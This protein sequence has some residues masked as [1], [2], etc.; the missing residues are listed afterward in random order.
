MMIFKRAALAV[1][2]G[3]AGGGTVIA[4]AAAEGPPL[5]AGACMGCHGADLA[6]VTPIVGIAGIHSEAE[7]IAIMTAFARNE[8][9]ATIMNR[10]AR[11]YS[12]AEIATLAAALAKR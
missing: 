5:I 8:R 6:G 7:F 12:D 2:I 11:G 9:P 1:V 10:I 3:V 4:Q